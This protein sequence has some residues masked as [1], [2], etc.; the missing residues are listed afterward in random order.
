MATLD[1]LLVGLG[2]E[3]D[4]EELEQFQ[5]DL[6]E[7]TS[8]IKEFAKTLV[9]GTVALVGFNVATTRASDEQ[10]KFSEEV[11]ILVGELD[12]L[13]FANR[14]AGGTADGMSA[15]LKALSSRIGEAARGV[16]SGVEAFGILGISVTKANGELKSTDEVLLEI[17]D[18][19]QGLS[20]SRQIELAEKLGVTDSLRLLQ[21]GSGAI[22]SL[23]EEARKL[24]VT[25]DEDAKSSAKFQDSL[26]DIWQVVKQVS[27][28]VSRS[29][30]PAMDNLAE[31]FTDWWVVNRE[32]IEQN[33][34]KFIESATQAIKFLTI[35]AGIFA[36]SKIF[37][38]LAS[39]ITLLRGATVAAL[40][41]NAAVMALP[42]I[43]ATL[44][45]SFALLA[46]DA[47]T[48][49]EGG[50]SFIGRMIEKYPQW[51][52]E[53]IAVASVFA[54]LFDLTTMI[55]KG[56]GEIFDLFSS[57]NFL[58]DLSRNIKQAEQDFRNFANESGDVFSRFGV[59]VLNVI[60]TIR[61][62]WS[63]IFD[64]ISEGNILDNF[65]L[66]IDQVGRDI[67]A[68][69]SRIEDKFKNLG[70]KVKEFFSFE[71]ITARV[72]GNDDDNRSPSN[73]DSEDVNTTQASTQL[74]DMVSELNR[75]Q[76]GI[77]RSIN[78]FES[79]V[80]SNETISNNETKIIMESFSKES[81][82]IRENGNQSPLQSQFSGGDVSNVS[83]S[84]VVR[85]ENIDIT[86]EAGSESPEL[87]ARTVMN[88]INDVAEQASF[89]LNSPVR[90]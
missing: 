9:A 10:G 86:V 81:E 28:V 32:L 89:E 7:T 57:G 70:T 8:I 85:L 80:A 40:L 65:L 55:F 72:F 83:S 15:S 76:D 90:L 87:I 61:D 47:N 30:T 2:F 35:A 36:A 73:V 64:F 27:R 19:F 18:K 74:S 42:T 24:G 71:N 13:Q 67:D 66:V 77:M 50:N 23:T 17:S 38:A 12:S 41:M 75:A 49:F 84:N 69:F 25:T 34:P 78:G 43:I 26:T 6:D 82:I 48:F 31:S 3:Y 14:R 33:V 11:G 53:L 54:T 37:T 4:P 44:I 29:L 46:E 52:T 68:L 39:L 63:G 58:E 16:G 45:A 88:H 22:A 20:R 1:E 21:Q 51:K 56:W 62:G 59:S 5:S 60:G 79:P